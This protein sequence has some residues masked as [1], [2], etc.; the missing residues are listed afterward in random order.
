MVFMAPCDLIPSSI[1]MKS[2]I[3]FGKNTGWIISEMKDGKNR[4]CVFPTLSN[5]ESYL[6]L[7]YFPI[8]P[9]R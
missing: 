2:Y 5:W 3:L 4:T 7:R 8:E 9:L 1:G 6:L